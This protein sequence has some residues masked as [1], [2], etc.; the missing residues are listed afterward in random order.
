MR[1][2]FSAL[3]LGLT[4]NAFGQSSTGSLCQKIGYAQTDY[5]IGHLPEFKKAEIDIRT[6]RARNW[7]IN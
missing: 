4:V 3:V 1:T 5:I 7:K 2:L 6:H